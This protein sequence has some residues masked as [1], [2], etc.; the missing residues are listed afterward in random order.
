MEG[1]LKALAAWGASPVSVTAREAILARIHAA[2]PEPPRDI[3]GSHASIQRLYRQTGTLDAHGRLDLFIDRLLDYDTE[4]I[5]IEAESELPFAIERALEHYD[6][7]RILAPAEFPSAW[8]P[9]S[10]PIQRDHALSTS[11]LDHFESIVTTCEIAIASTGTIVLV[12]GGAQGRRAATLLPDH[13]VCLVRRDQ[14][15]ETVPEGLAAIAAQSHRPIT[16][17]SGPSATADIE[18]TRIRG[19]H[20]PRRL[21]VI[22]YGR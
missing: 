20:G 5:Q 13:H 21:T 15:V 6:P 10:V 1:A 14:V 9:D 16:T 8:L 11:E 4:I 3:A 17:I 18:M 2:L 19:V 7:Q 12:H 22:L